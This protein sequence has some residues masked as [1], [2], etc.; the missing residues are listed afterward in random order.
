MN[1]NHSFIPMN[2]TSSSVSIGPLVWALILLLNLSCCCYYC[3]TTLFELKTKFSS[4]AMVEFSLPAAQ[5]LFKTR[6]GSPVT[7][8][9]S[10]CFSNS[11]RPFAFLS[12]LR[13]L[14][15]SLSFLSQ[16]STVLCK[17]H[18]ISIRHINLDGKILVTNCCNDDVV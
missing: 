6:T 3:L 12:F 13:F 4:P 11:G 15:S 1:K 8:V 9:P 17:I 14:S 2:A 18:T 5:P 7:R 10:T 16:L